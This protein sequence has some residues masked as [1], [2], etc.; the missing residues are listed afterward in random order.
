[1]IQCPPGEATA[2]SKARCS[3]LPDSRQ[4][5]SS[6]SCNRSRSTT[7]V[8]AEPGDPCGGTIFRGKVPSGIGMVIFADLQETIVDTAASQESSRVELTPEPS[9]G[10]PSA[11]S[12][13]AT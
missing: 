6:T 11:P 4:S 9:S 3:V 12:E 8:L 1:M 2:A 10:C 5:M 7:L 13:P